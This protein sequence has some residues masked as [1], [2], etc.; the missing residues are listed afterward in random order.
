VHVFRQLG[1]AAM[2][3]KGCGRKTDSPSSF[4]TRTPVRAGR[5][6]LACALLSMRSLSLRS[7]EA[8]IQATFLTRVHRG[9]DKHPFIEN[10]F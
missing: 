6:H 7:I 3:L 4:E 8:P 9:K 2:R 10:L 1:C 5:R